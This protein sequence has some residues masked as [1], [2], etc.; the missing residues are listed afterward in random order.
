MAFVVAL[1]VIAG[2]VYLEW[3][4]LKYLMVTNPKQDDLFFVLAISPIAAITSIVIF[5]L[6][7]VFRGFR[8]RDLN[9]LPLETASK[10]AFGNG[11]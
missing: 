10:E 7:G 3:Q 1:F 2:A 4:I 11:S 6:I 8:E 5:L 9:A